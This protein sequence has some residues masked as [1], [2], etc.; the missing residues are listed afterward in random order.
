M[1]GWIVLDNEGNQR[2][3]TAVSRCL[4]SA[5]QPFDTDSIQHTTAGCAI[6]PGGV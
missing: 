6:N 1:L 5:I 4:D 2:P 3:V